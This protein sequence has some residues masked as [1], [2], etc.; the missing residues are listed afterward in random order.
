MY[1][2]KR[3][4]SAAAGVITISEDVELCQSQVALKLL[5]CLLFTHSSPVRLAIIIIMSSIA[6]TH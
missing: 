6:G 5:L 3:C 1:L 2:Y 4:V